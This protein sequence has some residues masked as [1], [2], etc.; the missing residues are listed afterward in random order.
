MSINVMARCL[1]IAASLCVATASFR[2]SA[3]DAVTANNDSVGLGEVIVH[4]QRIEQPLQD[5]PVAVTPVSGPQLQAQALHDLPQLGLAVPSLE[6]TTDNAFT[7]RGIGSQIFSANVDSSVGVTVDDISLGVPIFMS[8]AAFLDIDQVEVLTG[9]QGLLFGRNASAGLLNIITQKPQIGKLGGNGTLEYD[10]RDTAPG[11][12][13]GLVA[14]AVL[15]LPTSANSALRLNALESDQD[16]VAK[17]VINISPDAQDNQQRLMGKAKWLWTPSNATSFYAIGDYSRER[18]AGGIWDSTWRVA[19]AGSNGAA[20]A[21]ADGAVPGPHNFLRGVNGRDFRS[22]DTYGTTLTFTQQLSDALTLS[23]IFGWRHYTLSY[24][25]DSDSSS[26]SDLD[27]NGGDESYNQ[28]SD[29]LRLAFKGNRIDGQGGLYFFK[30]NLDGLQQFDGTAG[31]PFE[32]VLYGQSGYQ[33]HGR[34]LAAYGQVNIHVSSALLF[35]VGARVTNDQLSVHAAAD[36]YGCLAK[37]FGPNGPCLPFVN[38]FGPQGQNYSDSRGHTNVSFKVGPQYNFTPDAMVY[39]TV[40]T[41]YKGP[42]M[43]TT[44][45][46]LTEDPY[47]KPETVTDYELGI[48]SLFFE[49]RLRIDLAGFLEKFRDFQVQAFNAAGIGTL[50]NANGVQS[51]GVEINTSFKALRQLTF[52]YNATIEDSHFTDFAGDPCYTNQP[53]STCPNGTYFQGAGIKTPTSATYTGTLDGVYS[54]PIGEGHF[55]IEAN[56]YHRSSVNFTTS[57]APFAEL[58]PI[59]IFGA[60][61]TYMPNE[62]LTLS[63]FCKNCSNDIYPTYIGAFPIDAALH[64]AVSTTQEWGFNSVR[65]LGVLVGYRY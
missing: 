22:V 5:V 46:T 47:L 36:D 29:E 34:S 44:L 42:A 35:I 53:A 4:A 48:K 6:T 64:H 26:R 62:H 14:T 25:L 16:P 65:T 55:D 28:Y 19:P 27:V 39:A 12:H 37:P 8:N 31:S 56:W 57:A 59:D 43:L 2:A 7:L 24:N 52:N 18:G 61:L 3:Q 63:L 54:I 51:S 11:G 9:P 49:R 13:F 17:N 38:I 20:D 45:A 21:A 60:N 1:A 58:G 23:D 33:L 41:G 50:T 15:N 40:S 32:H 30:Y 10:D